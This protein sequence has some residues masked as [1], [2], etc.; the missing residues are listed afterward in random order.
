MITEYR[1]GNLFLM[2]QNEGEGRFFWQFQEGARKRVPVAS[3]IVDENG[4]QEMVS[5][6]GGTET[7]FS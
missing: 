2:I 5:R 6:F 7:I 3:G 4:M 1:K